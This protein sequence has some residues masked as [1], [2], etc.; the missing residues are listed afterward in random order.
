MPALSNILVVAAAALLIWGGLGFAV[1]RLVVPGRGVAV[2][3]APALGW[4][5]FNAAAQPILL[6]LPF[7][8]LVLALCCATAL[9]VVLLLARLPAAVAET[10]SSGVPWWGYLAAAILALAPAMALMP[11]F[12]DG[13]IWL[14]DPIYDHS[15]VSMIDDIAR[16]G[17][18][19]GNPYFGDSDHPSRLG[20]YYLWHFGA[21]MIMRLLGVSGWEA[22]IGLTW[23]TAFASL[24][25]M[26][27]LAAWFSGRR[28]AALW[29]VLLCLALTARPIPALLLGQQLF[30]RLISVDTNLEG[31]LSQATWVPQHLASADCV[32]LAV[33]LLPL[34]G[35]SSSR[36]L[37]PVIGLLAAAGFES[38][39]WIGGF[40]LAFASPAI[41][42]WLWRSA[43]GD[44]RRRLVAAAGLAA[45]LALVLAASFLQDEYLG[46]KA[47]ALGVPIALKPYEVLGPLVPDEVRRSLDL[48][49]F[50]LI[51]LVLE[52]PAIVAT[53]VFTLWRTL[54]SAE[55]PLELRR[56]AGG[57][58]LLALAGFAICWLLASIIANNDL[59]WRAVL[60]GLMVLTIFAAAGL[61]DWLARRAWGAVAG[62]TFLYLLGLPDGV[63]FLRQNAVGIAS[64][65]A[66][67]LAASPALW[68]AVR[69]AAGPAERV[70]NNPLFLAGTLTWPV[71]ISWAL[72]ADRRSCF[73]GTALAE[74]YVAIPRA[75]IEGL[76]ALF[77]RVFAGAGSDEEISSLARRYQC[78]VIVVT[79]ADGVWAQDGFG[80]SADY[81]LFDERPGWWRIYRA[82][83]SADRPRPN[84]GSKSTDKTG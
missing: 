48:P 20:Y 60:P 68:A 66:P 63:A 22:D 5:L 8:R 32:T 62:A 37:V 16:L 55:I 12:V 25:L 72:F 28:L 52:F 19:A 35:R 73:A 56:Q 44:Q 4:A 65:T 54:R 40:A 57:L 30:G 79:P 42:L 36:L 9:L 80:R 17:L 13:G 50:W 1:G 7:D 75:E 53:G 64:P 49:A 74:A 23:V 15:K 31:W 38:S 2:A 43:S 84:E 41:G 58:A 14:A 51:F 39:I 34:L 18:P 67:V 26:M 69:K 70:G 71:N 61:A 81:R 76:E 77:D 83:D 46:A 24:S 33:W 10:P 59:G 6:F 21:A 78:Q 82:T 11:K 27:G 3:I 29:V 47:R 45:I